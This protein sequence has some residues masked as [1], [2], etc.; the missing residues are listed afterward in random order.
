M[1]RLPRNVLP[2][3]P[4][5]IIQ[6]GNNRQA[7]FFAEA[8]YPLYLKALKR[9]ADQHGCG[10][11]A[12]VLMTNHVHILVTPG[13]EIGPSR[14]MQSVGRRYVRYVN[15]RHRRTGTLWEG[16]YRSALVDSERHLL[17][18]MR[19]IEMNP[20][21]AGMA[22]DSGAYHW[23]SFAANAWGRPDGLV[24]PHP[25]YQALG[26]TESA[27]R[28]VYRS[29]FEDPVP[30]GLLTLIR[31]ATE[32]GEVIGNERFR[33]RIAGELGRRVRKFAHGGNRKGGS[34]GQGSRGQST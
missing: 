8:D 3:L 6:R 7:V 9:S 18:C 20:V 15:D 27:R 4:L 19:Y 14:M 12:Y 29:L 26:G 28:A 1:A 17:A 34:R 32:R 24:T 33:D 5:H 16:R 10:V 13:T 31:G 21:R 23:S 2:G 25:L 30:D 22:A 11:H